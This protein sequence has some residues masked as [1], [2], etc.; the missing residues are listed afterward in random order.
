MYTFLRKQ[1]YS[2]E[3][4]RQRQSKFS[5]SI[6]FSIDTSHFYSA[7]V[8][9][10]KFKL[11]WSALFIQKIIKCGITGIQKKNTQKSN[12]QMVEQS[13]PQKRI[14]KGD[15]SLLTISCLTPLISLNNNDWATLI[16]VYYSIPVYI[17]IHLMK[18]AT[19]CRP[20]N[21]IL[22]M[23]L[24]SIYSRNSS[25]SHFIPIAFLFSS[26]VSSQIIYICNKKMTSA[27]CQ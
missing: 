3:R 8:K 24:L 20:H 25:N 13:C 9:N 17:F 6:F 23:P 11:D 12:I 18:L 14:D 4:K 10:V 15:L 7:V 19:F 27:L 26:H 2:Q 16:S 5:L 1:S 21:K 22:M